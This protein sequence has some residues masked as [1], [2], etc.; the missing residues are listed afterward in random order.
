MNADYSG[1]ISLSTERI[2]LLFP[3]GN[4]FLYYYMRVVTT[5][6]NGHQCNQEPKTWK[7][8]W[9]LGDFKVPVC[10]E[11]FFLTID[12]RESLYH[13]MIVYPFLTF[14]VSSTSNHTNFLGSFISKFKI[15][16]VLERLG[17]FSLC[18]VSLK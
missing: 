1:R 14:R 8:C 15:T 4:L 18:S 7:L 5:F 17:D 10:S 12:K 9:S 16:I 11:F 13:E 6:V 3:K 2:E